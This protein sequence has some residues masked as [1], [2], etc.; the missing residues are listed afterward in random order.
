MDLSDIPNLTKI[1]K[2]LKIIYFSDL[3]EKHQENNIIDIL[4]KFSVCPE[5]MNKLINCGIIEF[6]PS[7]NTLTIGRSIEKYYFI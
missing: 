4:I 1:W 3:S 6:N 5:N 7:N 2:H